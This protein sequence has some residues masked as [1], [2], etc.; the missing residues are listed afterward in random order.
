MNNI[1]KKFVLAMSL[2]MIAN[3]QS[4]NN[5]DNVVK[6]Q[7]KET[8]HKK[9]DKFEQSAVN[10]EKNKSDIIKS[11]LKMGQQNANVE[12]I[13]FFDPTGAPCKE[14][15]KIVVDMINN[16]KNIC[17]YLL[18]VSIL[19]EQSESVTKI[20]YQL[21]ELDKNKQSS[22]LQEFL[23]EITKGINTGDKVLDIIKV[24]KYDLIRYSN[25]ANVRMDSNKNFLK[26]L[27]IVS[28]PAVFVSKHGEN[29]KIV[30]N[31][32]SLPE[33]I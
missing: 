31:Y 22:K 9:L 6:E 21:Q 25:A 32:N 11:S 29:Y 13:M 33:L 8:V 10:V 19:G 30:R 7:H 26:T 16:N 17:V 28:L 15:Q 1:S 27:K 5:S 12:I 24:N 2:L 3:I 20:Y 23:N 18:P 14:A 4:K